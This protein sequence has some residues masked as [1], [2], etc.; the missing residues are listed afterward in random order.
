MRVAV[1]A[2]VLL[3]F[4]MALFFLVYAVRAINDGSIFGFLV[5]AVMGMW[6]LYVVRAGL[7]LIPFLGSKI[8]VDNL[9]FRI[10]RGGGAESFHW[11]Q[12]LEYINRPSL[13]ILEV[14]DRSGNTIL[15]IDHIIPNFNV[16]LTGLKNA[17]DIR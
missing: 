7:K 5:M 2:G 1:R 14:F 9:G 11:N 12:N 15:V 4:G 3:F 10:F 6:T 13:Q 16:F 8:E 17:N